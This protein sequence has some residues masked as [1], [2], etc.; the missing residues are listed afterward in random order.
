MR[1]DISAKGRFL[2]IS[3]NCCALSYSVATARITAN[4]SYTIA[5]VFAANADLLI[6][7]L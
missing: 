7:A 2:I 4:I 3:R 5:D 1:D 6:N